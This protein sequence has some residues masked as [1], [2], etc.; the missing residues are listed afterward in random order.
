MN[1]YLERQRLTIVLATIFLNVVSVLALAHYPGS[2]WK[3]GLAL[4]VADNILLLV[5]VFRMRDLLMLRLMFFGLV[6]G[7]AELPADALLAGWTGT[8][9]YAI[10]GGPMIWKSPVWM[11]MAWEVVAVQFGYIGLRLYEA[12]GVQGLVVNGVLGAIN[13]PF[14]EEMALRVHWWR[15]SEC[16]MVMHTPWYVIT[17]EFFIA[18]ALGRL[19]TCA[20]QRS[21]TRIFA[22]GALGGV[23]ILMSYAVAYLAIDRVWVLMK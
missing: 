8:L 22:M 12:M 4:N 10:G 11:P 16:R 9:D 14:Y 23:T 6:A 7:F 18:M 17:A 5:H 1:P 15:Y 20:R 13:I 3:T 19:A 21:V 2:D